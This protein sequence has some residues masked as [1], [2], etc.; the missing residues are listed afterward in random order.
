MYIFF[1]D[2]SKYWNSH[3]LKMLEQVGS[4]NPEDPS[5]KFLIILDRAP[6]IYKTMKLIFETLKL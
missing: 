5:N 4:T 2:I 6:N 1:W 3:L